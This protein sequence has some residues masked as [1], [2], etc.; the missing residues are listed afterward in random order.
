VR[1]ELV[2]EVSYSH[3]TADGRL[4]HPVYLGQRSDVDPEAVV[5]P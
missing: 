5:R 4:R 3:W 2:V 1:P